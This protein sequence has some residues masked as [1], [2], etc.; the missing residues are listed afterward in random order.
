[1]SFELTKPPSLPAPERFLTGSGPSWNPAPGR[2][3]QPL[4][5]SSRRAEGGHRS[6]T[7]RPSASPPSPLA[8]GEPGVPASAS[9][10]TQYVQESRKADHSGEVTQSHPVLTPPLSPCISVF[11]PLP[12]CSPPITGSGLPFPPASS[13]PAYPPSTSYMSRTHSRWLCVGRGCPR[14]SL[15]QVTRGFWEER[16]DLLL[17]RGKVTKLA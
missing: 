10:K 3:P 13:L 4:P 7:D 9:K 11:S 14:P 12:V 1:M 6:H 5:E 8:A 16:R 15:L 17:R 2:R